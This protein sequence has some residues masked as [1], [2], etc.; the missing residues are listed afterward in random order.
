MHLCAAVRVQFLLLG[1]QL[2][3]LTRH[4]GDL[5]HLHHIN[6]LDYIHSP[7][8]DFI[9]QPPCVAPSG[10]CARV[11]VNYANHQHSSFARRR[12]DVRQAAARRCKVHDFITQPPCVATSGDCARVSVNYANHQHSPFARRRHDIRQAAARR[13]KLHFS[14]YRLVKVS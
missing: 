13:C 3:E 8:H 2:E 4:V 11:I 9:T 1:W 5:L 14:R 6:R 7:A 12:H 10:D